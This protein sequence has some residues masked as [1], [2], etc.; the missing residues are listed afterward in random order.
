MLEEIVVLSPANIIACFKKSGVYPYDTNAIAI[1]SQAK[2]KAQLKIDNP[3][4]AMCQTI[5]DSNDNERDDEL[6]YLFGSDNI[7]WHK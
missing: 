2:R 5:E 6:M 4:S 7:N 1:P 3:V